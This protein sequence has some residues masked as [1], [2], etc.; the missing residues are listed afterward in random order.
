[1]GR[2]YMPKVTIWV[3]EDDYEDWMQI[4]DRPSAIAWLIDIKRKQLQKEQDDEPA[5]T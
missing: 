4:A 3:R 5:D 1:M 2:K